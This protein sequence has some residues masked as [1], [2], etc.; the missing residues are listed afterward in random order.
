MQSPSKRYEWEWFSRNMSSLAAIN[1][2]RWCALVDLVAEAD[3]LVARLVDRPLSYAEERPQDYV[4][5]ILAVRSFRLSTSAIW[6]AASG[7]PDSAPNLIRTVWEIGIR[8]LDLKVSPVAGALGFLL[9]GEQIKVATMKAESDYRLARGEATGNLDANMQAARE[10][11]SSLEAFSLR[12]GLDPVK[13]RKSH[14]RLK[15]GAICREHGIEK[16]YFVNYRDMTGYAH[17]SNLASNE[18]FAASHGRGRFDLGPITYGSLETSVDALTQLALTLSHAVDVI[19]DPQLVKPAELFLQ[20]IGDR[21]ALAK[22]AR[23][24]IG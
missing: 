22:A 9:E 19:Q 14:G 7:Y 13:I 8:L 5:S 1:G 17:E 6:L 24:K 2:N 16:A 10:M 21:Y 11:I 15:F 3:A 18:F 23:A 4:A 20:G 12:H